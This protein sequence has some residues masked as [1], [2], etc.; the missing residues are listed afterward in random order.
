LSIV[1]GYLASLGKSLAKGDATEHTHRPALKTLIEASIKGL[2]ATNEPKSAERENKPDY[3]VRKGAATIGFIEAKDVDKGLKAVLKSTQIKRYL[4]ALP[5]LLITNYVDFVWYVAGEKRMEVSLAD[6]DGKVIRP[7]KDAA[8]RWTELITS[9]TNEVT[10]TVSTPSQLAR[11]LAG[12]TR[13]LRDLVAELV[14]AGDSDLQSQQDAFQT[15]LVPDLKPEE[16]ADMYAQTAAYGLF[17]ARVFE[18][19]TLFGA[20][21]EKLP[22]SLR[23]APF[24]LEKAAYLIPKANPFLRQFFQHIASPNLNQQ[25]RWLIEQ[26]AASLHYADL[27]RVLHRQGR[28]QG[29]E[30]PVFH[31]YET[32]LSEYDAKLR[33][34]RGVYYTPQPVVDFIVRGVDSLLKT[35]FDNP[36][37]WQTKTP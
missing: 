23:D 8:S 28:R 36:T 18:F 19:T 25:L 15:L 32:F 3:V 24:N 14:V 30:D 17:T 35:H 34:S 10:P 9:F 22:P 13:L 33:E 5:N 27:D 12:Q 7:A 31:F 4:D 37:V 2:E 21:P 16:F 29:F 20:T 6:L 1:D 26:I 11:S